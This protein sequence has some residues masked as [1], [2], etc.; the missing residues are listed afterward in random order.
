MR[1][2]IILYYES[3]VNVKPTTVEMKLFLGIFSSF[4]GWERNMYKQ[5]GCKS[6]E[7]N[8]NFLMG[9]FWGSSDVNDHTETSVQFTDG[10]DIPSKPIVGHGHPI[11]PIVSEWSFSDGLLLIMKKIQQKSVQFEKWPAHLVVF[12]SDSRC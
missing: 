3:Q 8:Q 6:F 5:F 11:A 9:I 2:N 12:V 7:T 10:H 1:S 4:A